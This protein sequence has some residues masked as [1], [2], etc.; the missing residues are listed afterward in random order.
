M[1]TLHIVTSVLIK[2]LY[3]SDMAFIIILLW[4]SHCANL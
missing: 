4:E 3:V 2:P 1:Y